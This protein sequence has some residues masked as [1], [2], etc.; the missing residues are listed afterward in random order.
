MLGGF[1][2]EEEGAPGISSCGEADVH[3]SA[4]K[5]AKRVALSLCQSQW[6][7]YA[8]LCIVSVFLHAG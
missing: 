3:C 2:G 4:K 8:Q 1:R 6:L 7:R 5:L